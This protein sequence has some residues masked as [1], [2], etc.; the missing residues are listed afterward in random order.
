M[1][2]MV[3][4]VGD[5]DTIAEPLIKI[6]RGTRLSA[7]FL[8]D[9]WRVLNEISMAGPEPLRGFWPQIESRKRENMLW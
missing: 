5:L 6:R 8:N 3:L 4:C 9:V 7:L 2:I 1:A